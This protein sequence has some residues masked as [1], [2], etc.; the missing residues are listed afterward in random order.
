MIIEQHYDEEVLIGL[1]EEADHDSHVPG[2]ETCAGTLESLR[3]LTGALRDNSVWDERQLS[4]TPAPK[5][6][7]LLRAFA[8][9]T[10]AEDAAAA[11]IVPKLISAPAMIEAHPEWRTAGV[12][13]KLLAVV[14]EKNFFEP[15]V[16]ADVAALA[17]EVAE[18]IEPGLYPLDT[19]LKLRATAWRERAY[20]LY[21]IGSF[22]DSLAA[23][24]R[25]D[26]LLRSCAVSEYDSARA[27]LV[28]AQVY[29]EIERFEAG[30]A[31][32]GSARDVFTRFDDFNRV[33]AADST[34]GALL[35]QVR[36]FGQALAI[37]AGLASNPRL[38][39]TSR[40]FA[41]HNAAVCMRE[42]A[43]LNEAKELFAQAVT[44]FEHL[45]ISSMRARARWHLGS[46]LVAEQKFENAFSIF[47]EVRVEF[48]ELGMAQDV[49][50][51][52]VDAAEA[53]L[54]LDRRDQ[55]VQLC[56]AAI[57]YFTKA[58]LAYTQGALTALAYLKEAAAARTLTPSCVNKVRAYFELLPK[59][60]NL[61][62]AQ[63][64]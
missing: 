16:A 14:D 48:Q 29:G 45:R 26:H 43:R 53:L 1:L 50:L 28:R 46:V 4:E 15:K 42:L 30:I 36:R 8:E 22:I 54:T 56:Q 57:E 33:S 62:F 9:R 10:K 3:D 59:Q 35:M 63:L 64:T 7:N 61:A 20:A 51:V 5:T 12:V 41:L 17:V 13:R 40:A 39:R 58:Q 37:Q 23:L 34:K 47:D 52:S 18:S 44:E 6:T 24:D 38:D 27:Q 32:A 19:I 2:C 60:P 31:L 21:Y 55:V 49:A 11:A 25:T